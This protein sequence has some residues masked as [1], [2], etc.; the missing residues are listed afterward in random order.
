MQS[1]VGNTSYKRET[2]KISL[3]SSISQLPHVN[4]DFHKP[5]HPPIFTFRL[6]S[7]QYTEAAKNNTATT[8]RY[9]QYKYT[10]PLSSAISMEKE[11]QLYNT[12]SP[13]A[14]PV[15]VVSILCIHVHVPRV[16]A[17]TT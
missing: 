17:A 8:V 9:W 1:V 5:S 12:N 11:Y 4:R 6:H 16:A 3:I 2:K 14:S 7:Q 15:T 13:S 10:Q